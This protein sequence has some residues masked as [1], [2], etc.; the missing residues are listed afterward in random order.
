MVRS[1]DIQSIL[2]NR[3]IRSTL[4]RDYPLYI[5]VALL[6]NINFSHTVSIVAKRT[7]IT[8]IIAGFKRNTMG[9]ILSVVRKNL[10]MM[11]Q[12][13]KWNKIHNGKANGG[14][15]LKVMVLNNWNN[16]SAMMIP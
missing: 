12:M 5:G 2:I 7:N 9:L 4:V 10:V 11:C 15:H 8:T 3:E 6:I 14:V 13:M 16:P 1:A